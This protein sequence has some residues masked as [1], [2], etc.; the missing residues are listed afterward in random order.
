[1]ISS[2]ALAPAPVWALAAAVLP[3]LVRGSSLARDLAAAAAWAS[4]LVLFTELAISVQH[5]GA[6]AASLHSVV[7]GALA[8]VA[9]AIAPS[10]LA[11]WRK[12]HGGY[13]ESRVP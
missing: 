12:M 9:V 1:L 5:V 7:V 10:A 13:T 4:L 3:L 2:G 8:A 11:A 6:A